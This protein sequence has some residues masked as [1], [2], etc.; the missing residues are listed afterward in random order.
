MD[1]QILLK[2]SSLSDLEKLNA[3]LEST[4]ISSK[5]VSSNASPDLNDHLYIYTPTQV[6]KDFCGSEC[7]NRY[8]CISLSSAKEMVLHYAKRNGLYNATTILVDHTISKILNTN[9][10]EISHED[11]YTNLKSLFKKH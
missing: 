8:G 2:V 1:T 3:F 11:V 5:I 6:F 10:R 9:E 4:S 7:L